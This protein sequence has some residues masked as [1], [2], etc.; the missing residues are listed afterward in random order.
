M[1]NDGTIGEIIVG[2]RS[3]LITADSSAWRRIDRPSV[4]R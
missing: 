2:P 4:P 1:Q 3:V